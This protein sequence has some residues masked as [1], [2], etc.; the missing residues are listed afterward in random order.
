LIIGIWIV[1]KKDGKEALI[2]EIKEKV[3][4]LLAADNIPEAE[5][6]KLIR[7]A[8]KVLEDGKRGAVK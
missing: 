6:A 8:L 7:Q 4:E 1:D 5:K 3:E 2:R